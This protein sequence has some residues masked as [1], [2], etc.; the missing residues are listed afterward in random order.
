MDIIVLM[1]VTP[2]DSD[3]LKAILD[4]T[5]GNPEVEVIMK[6]D[7]LRKQKKSEY[8]KQ[9][10]QERKNTTVK[11]VESTKE[12]EREAETTRL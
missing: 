7:E 4:R 10:Y 2:E 6:N 9:R 11:N 5:L 1:N 3:S 8:D 12:E